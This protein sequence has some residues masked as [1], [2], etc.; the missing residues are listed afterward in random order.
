MLLHLDLFLRTH[1]LHL[2]LP[3]LC[4]FFTNQLATSVKHSGKLAH[5]YAPC[6]RKGPLFSEAAHENAQRHRQ[7]SCHGMAIP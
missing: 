4:W 7:L 2:D 1:A 3:L 6:N 5:T